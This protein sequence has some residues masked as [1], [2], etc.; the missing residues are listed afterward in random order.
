MRVEIFVD[1]SFIGLQESINAFIQNKKIID[2]K[3]STHYTPVNSSF[4]AYEEF[5]ALI[6]YEGE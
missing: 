4:H 2:I 6:I 5:C 1:D 3:F